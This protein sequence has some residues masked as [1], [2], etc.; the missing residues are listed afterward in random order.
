M[1]STD[2]QKTLA[3]TLGQHYYPP[4]GLLTTANRR[5]WAQWRH[6]LLQGA[7]CLLRC[8]F[9][10]VFHPLFSFFFPFVALMYIHATSQSIYKKK[11]LYKCIKV[12]LFPGSFS[13][14]LAQPNRIYNGWYQPHFFFLKGADNS[15]F[16]CS[17]NWIH[18]LSS[19]SLSVSFFCVDLI[20]ARSLQSIESSSMIV[21]IDQPFR[22]AVDDEEEVNNRVDTNRVLQMIHGGGSQW[23]TINRWFDK[24]VQVIFLTLKS[25]PDSHSV[26]NQIKRC[27]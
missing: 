21:C 5:L 18:F 23:N 14:M 12:P 27:V 17:F 20:N 8:Q 3:G 22:P 4:L 13:S 11:D 10:P 24:T 1:E 9:T 19:F 25:I 15:S 2:G 26:S 6:Q 16:F 7:A